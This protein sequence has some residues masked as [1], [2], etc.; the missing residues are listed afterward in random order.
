[1]VER[2]D[3]ADKAAEKNRKAAL[4]ATQVEQ[5]VTE[6]TAARARA[7]KMEQ[8][9]AAMMAT[10]RARRAS[11]ALVMRLKVGAIAH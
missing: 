9:G 3:D 5:E 1:M 7:A 11:V 4:K 10:I 2:A 6:K 8:D